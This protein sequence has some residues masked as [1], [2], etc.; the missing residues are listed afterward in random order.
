MA[1]LALAAGGAGVAAAAGQSSAGA[2]SRLDDGKDLLGQAGISEP[3]AIVA[4]QGAATG[5]LNEVD[6]EHRNGRLVFNVDVGK[7]DVKVDA[8]NGRVLAVD[9]DD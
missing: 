1:A 9:S 8:A 6:L 2:P 4:A 7:H 3:Q 5:S